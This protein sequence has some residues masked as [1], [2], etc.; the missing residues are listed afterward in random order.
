MALNRIDPHQLVP[1]PGVERFRETVRRDQAEHPTGD[2]SNRT[3]AGRS[4]LQDRAEISETAHK[5]MQIRG[6][7]ESGRESLAALPEVRN[8]KLAAAKERLARGYY[9]SASVAGDVAA[10]LNRTFD[11]IDGL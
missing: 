8:D 1:Q 11:A 7:V 6:D 5:L 10:K 3:G 9:H 4:E 2:D